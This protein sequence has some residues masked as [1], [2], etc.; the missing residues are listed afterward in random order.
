MIPP[1]IAQAWNATAYSGKFCKGRTRTRREAQ[2]GIHVKSDGSGKATVAAAAAH[3]WRE[4]RE[5]QHTGEMIA[6]T[7]PFLNPREVSPAATAR[8]CAFIA[9]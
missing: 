4:A 9:E 6:M 2:W 5:A 8:I 3:G 7:S 1:M